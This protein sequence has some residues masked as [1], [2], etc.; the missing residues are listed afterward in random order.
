MCAWHLSDFLTDLHFASQPVSVSAGVHHVQQNKASQPEIQAQLSPGVSNGSGGPKHSTQKACRALAS[1]SHGKGSVSHRSQ[2]R[3]R[4]ASRSIFPLGLKHRLRPHQEPSL[5]TAHPPTRDEPLFV[6]PEG[7]PPL[8]FSS[9]FFLHWA[10]S[11]PLSSHTC[12]VPAPDGGPSHSHRG[13]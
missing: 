5:A 1:A 6:P 10:P 12:P 11:Q 13:T 9:H 2:R 3:A 7:K 4:P 8:R